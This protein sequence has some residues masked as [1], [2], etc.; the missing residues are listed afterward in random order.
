MPAGFKNNT[1]QLVLDYFPATDT[2]LLFNSAEQADAFYRKAF[3]D[4]FD[5][6][7]PDASYFANVEEFMQTAPFAGFVNKYV[8]QPAAPRGG[9]YLGRDR[10]HTVTS[11]P[12]NT[13]ANTPISISTPFPAQPSV[14]QQS[15]KESNKQKARS[16]MSS[17]ASQSTHVAA[18]TKLGNA[19]P[20]SKSSQR[21]ASANLPQTYDTS[22]SSSLVAGMLGAA[23]LLL[24]CVKRTIRCEA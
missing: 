13:P 8:P 11:T 10:S 19:R 17:D 15:S 12:I 20:V 24:L 1:Q 7:N 6:A 9:D 23:A 4:R 5:D 2:S 21:D 16:I 22:V 18:A 3:I 14:L